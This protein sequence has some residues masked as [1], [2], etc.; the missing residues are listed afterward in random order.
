MNNEPNPVLEL[1]F[2]EFTDHVVELA[3]RVN[4]CR[5]ELETRFLNGELQVDS[6]RL[7]LAD[8]DGGATKRYEDALDALKRFVEN[9]TGRGSRN[10][11]LQWPVAANGELQDH[12]I[13]AVEVELAHSG[14]QVN[15][16]DIPSWLITGVVVRGII[17][18]H[19]SDGNEQPKYSSQS[20]SSS[21]SSSSP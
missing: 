5:T 12:A 21:V 2:G 8:Y 11:N 18:V 7:S 3:R 20:R 1:A 17:S 10:R 13:R 16:Q 19:P 4:L 9:R 14:G 15:G 6:K